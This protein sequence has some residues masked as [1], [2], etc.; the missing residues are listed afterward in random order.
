LTAIMSSEWVEEVEH[1]SKKFRFVLLLQPS[2]A[3]SAGSW[4]TRLTIQLL[5]QTTC[6]HLLHAP[7]DEPI[8][9]T[10]KNFRVAPHSRLEG[11]GI[12]H[13]KMLSLS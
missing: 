2:N 5:G 10:V 6:P 8:A 13:I 11:L 12:L 3:I 7:G 1:S 4:W 9:P